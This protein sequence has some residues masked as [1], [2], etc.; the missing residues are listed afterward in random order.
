[1]TKQKVISPK[2]H[3]YH[4]GDICQNTIIQYDDKDFCCTGCQSVFQ[5]L[6]ENN[7]CNYYAITHNP[8]ATQKNT[9]TTSYYDFLDDQSTIEKLIKFRNGRVV[10]LNFTIPHMH[11]SSCIWLLENMCK[12]NQGISSSKVD[13]LQKQ[14][15]IVFDEEKISMKEIVIWLKK[16]GY[17]P[18]LSLEDLTAKQTTKSNRSQ[19]YKIGIA[20]FC[21]GNIMMLSLPHY[22][23]EGHFFADGML[24][25]L[26]N[27]LT[28]ALSLPVFFYCA[29]EFF[30]SSYQII[31]QKKINIDVPITL[32]IVI[33][34]IVSLV[35]TFGYNK[36]GYLDSM[37]GIVFFMLLGRFFQN[38]SYN[39]LTFQK[40]FASYL[41]IAVNKKI[42]GV[43][44]S[45]PLTQILVGDEIVTRHLEVVPADAI[46]MDENA[47]YDY[48]FVTGESNWIE[49][50]RGETI[51]AGAIQQS[52]AT[53]LKVSKN[54]TQSYITDLWNSNQQLKFQ[55]NTVLT[56]EKINIY[57]SAIVL[58]LG[59]LSMIYWSIKGQYAVGLTSLITVWIVACPCALLLSST[60]TY[61]NILTILA[62]N[63]LYIK[64]AAVLERMKKVNIL[65]FDKTGTITET[66]ASN[67]D[68]I[69]RDLIHDEQTLAYSLAFQSTHPLSRAIVNY[70]EINEL[71]SV[72]NF[73]SINGKGI[74]GMID[75]KK[76]MLGSENWVGVTKEN[77]FNYST[78]F[79]KINDEI[80]GYFEIKNKYRAGITE[81]LNSFK[82][83]YDIHLLSGDNPVEKENLEKIFT[84]SSTLNFNQT[85][86][87][88]TAYI[89]KLQ[90]ENKV[91]MMIGD[92]LNDA[93]AFEK[94]DVGMAVLE[95]ENNFLPSCDVILLANK[96]NTLNAFMQFIGTAKIILI[97]CFLVSVIYNVVGL[98]Y[99]MQGKLTPVVAAVL[100][101]I[102]TISIVGMSFLLS[103]YFAKRNNLSL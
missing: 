26:F 38:K 63:G 4:C 41:P 1:M 100:M 12:L 49:K 11:C 103:R 97:S 92:G 37:S 78:V 61:G 45:T 99:A 29:E 65:V 98:S 67:V 68:F 81:L 90:D 48:S 53:I 20:G 30:V 16:I 10:H 95:D 31:K 6:S 50:H 33:A 39:Y 47:W 2:I 40:T 89:K 71:F 13:F 64:N 83:H 15:Q 84:N 23:S 69:G 57:F 73:N 79:F 25:R 72:E 62:S 93:N 82:Q 87:Q 32:A 3:C 77:K 94:S 59:I 58:G 34:F 54:P 66:S 27:Y 24:N 19:L 28:V 43:E 85:P 86:E 52:T 60:F 22:F 36:L 102:S 35:L 75:G 70:I 91:V 21:F 9:H 76:I 8:G 74:E 101:P 56:T 51:Y 14:L 55:S 42:N 46:L 5:I 80:V 44:K 17:E 18:N 7:L 88:K 96:M